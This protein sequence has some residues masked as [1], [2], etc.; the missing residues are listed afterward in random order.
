VSLA[1]EIA[2]RVAEVRARIE[3]AARRAGRDP[4]SV[5]LVG[6]SKTKPL[7]MLLAAWDAGIRAFGE[8][9]VHEAEAKFPHLPPG[10]ARHFIGPLQSNKAKRVAEVADVV[11][12]LD[13]LDVGRRLS[14]AAEERGKTLAVFVE[15]N[16]GGEATKAGLLQGE[17]APFLDAVRALPA[18]ELRGLMAIPPRGDTRPH[19][20]RLAKLARAHALF[21]LSMGMSADFEDAIE[22]GA[23]VVRVGTAIFGPR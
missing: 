14:R 4:A 2:G 11:E 3:R 15:V 20:A 9:R 19:F 13:S 12:S 22:E 23:T 6:V 10:A 16:L 1:E 8:N 18:L 7:E 21:G 17:L 5:T